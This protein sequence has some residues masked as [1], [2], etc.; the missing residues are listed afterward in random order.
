M[1]LIPW[2]NQIVDKKKFLCSRSISANKLV[3][4]EGIFACSNDIMSLDKN[5]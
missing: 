1:C 3:K 5:S 2:G 4:S